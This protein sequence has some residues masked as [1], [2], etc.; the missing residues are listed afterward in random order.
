MS[1]PQIPKSRWWLSDA[2]F[3]GLRILRPFPGESEDSSTA[4]T[5]EKSNGS[6]AAP[7]GGEAERQ[8]E[9]R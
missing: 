1:D 9:D 7:K 4:E 3:A 5:G 2:P 6:E 8:K